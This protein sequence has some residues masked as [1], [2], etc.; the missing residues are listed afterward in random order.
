MPKQ[1][2]GNGVDMIVVPAIREREQLVEEIREPG[3]A[4]RQVNMTR[5]DLS[6]L[7]HPP[8][9]LR[10]NS[11]RADYSFN[12]PEPEIVEKVHSR[13]RLLD[14]YGCRAMVFS[15]SDDL[16]P[17]LWIFQTAAIDLREVNV[18][19]IDVPG[20]AE[21]FC[22]PVVVAISQLCTVRDRHEGAGSVS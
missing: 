1:E 11:Y 13:T 14:E 16:A 15:Q 9:E 5:L 12:H 18:I 7:G 6:R 3:R 22:A 10:P 2:L 17:Q 8:I 19:L 21:S 4:F 20:R